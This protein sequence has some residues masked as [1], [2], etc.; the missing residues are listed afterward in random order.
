MQFAEIRGATQTASRIR[1]M[2]N[3]E[4]SWFARAS[5][6]SDEVPAPHGR[7]AP[8]RAMARR[9]VRG[10]PGASQSLGS[11][12]GVKAASH[13]PLPDAALGPHAKPSD[14]SAPEVLCFAETYATGPR[15]APRIPGPRAPTP[16]QFARQ[17]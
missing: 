5:R 8:A 14:E 12:P 10:S 2:D 9:R 3:A 17:M 4:L 13:P 11:C 15:A 1:D 6:G 16:P 7:R